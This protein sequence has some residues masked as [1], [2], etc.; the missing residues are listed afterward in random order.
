MYEAVAG[1]DH[2]ADRGIRIEDERIPS[3]SGHIDR[4]FSGSRQAL[5]GDEGHRVGTGGR[6][7]EDERIV[8]VALAERMPS[9]QEPP[10]CANRFLARAF[11]EAVGWVWI[12]A[13]LYAGRAIT[14]RRG[15]PPTPSLAI[16]SARD[17]SVAGDGEDVVGSGWDER[18]TCSGPAVQAIEHNRAIAIAAGRSICHR[19]MSRQRRALQPRQARTGSFRRRRGV[20]R[21]TARRGTP[22]SPRR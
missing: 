7:A 2:P 11:L 10:S 16:P 22:G 4:L 3:R 19:G 13:E 20:F 1:H 9:D 6:D 12:P 5:T 15:Q 17:P 8:R 21:R 14:A 18:T